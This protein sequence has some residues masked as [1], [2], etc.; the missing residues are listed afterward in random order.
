MR[1]YCKTCYCTYES[2]LLDR[3]VIVDLLLDYGTVTPLPNASMRWAIDLEL[4]APR[5]IILHMG[6]HLTPRYLTPL[7]YYLYGLTVFEDNSV[8]DPAID[9]MR[10]SDLYREVASVANTYMSNQH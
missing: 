5:N 2:D 1:R 8:L 6:R 4:D 7:R 3:H 10:L 9:V